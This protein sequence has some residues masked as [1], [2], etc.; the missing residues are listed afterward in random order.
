MG[1]FANLSFSVGNVSLRNPS[2][3]RCRVIHKGL[4]DLT[5]SDACQTDD[6]QLETPALHGTNIT[7][8]FHSG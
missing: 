4:S 7:A 5:R 3:R 6:S 1:I 8:S 2:S